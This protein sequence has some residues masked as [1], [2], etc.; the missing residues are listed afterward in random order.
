[1]PQVI[2]AYLLDKYEGVGP[3]LL[4]PTPELRAKAQL[5]GRIHDLYIQPLQVRC[6]CCGAADPCLRAVVAQHPSGVTPAAVVCLPLA[7]AVLLTCMLCSRS[8]NA[9][10]PS[11]TVCTKQGCMYKKM[12]AAARCEQL[13][14]IDFQLDVLEGIFDEANGPFVAGALQRSLPCLVLARLV[15][16]GPIAGRAVTAAW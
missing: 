9:R 14:S 13:Q 12:D 15:V 4:P 8:T 5:A 10:L 16:A 6:C 3:S 11:H 7:V 1:M 2:E